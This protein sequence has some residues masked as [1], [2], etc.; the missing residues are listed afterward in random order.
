MI[1]A[2]RGTGSGSGER[3]PTT[4][5]MLADLMNNHLDGGYEAAARRRESRQPPSRTAQRLR[6]GTVLCCLGLIGLILA[7]AYSGTV[8]DAPDAARTRDALLD[9]V[10]R[11]AAET[12]RLGDRTQRLRETVADEQDAALA[13]DATGQAAARRLREAEATVG[14]AAVRGPGVAVELADGPPPTDPVTG[15]P[16][17]EA[18][19]GRVQDRDLQDVVNA[20]WQAG[21]EAVA[22][23]SQRLAATSTIRSAGQAIL[24]DFRPVDSPYVVSA[25]GDPDALYRA[26]VDSTTARRFRGYAKKYRMGFDV[27]R[28]DD[29]TLGAAAAPDLRFAQVPRAATAM[30]TSRGTPAS[31]EPPPTTPA[32]P[33]TTP[34]GGNR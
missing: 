16:T 15:Q 13:E 21:A 22:V 33:T 32:A 6:R 19:L 23:D 28:E 17:G 7:V 29:M 4:S 8:A 30:P 24:V 2:E 20:L 12:D 26:F 10:R 5:T 25:V 3:G 34:T 9:T 14:L 18:D 1:P 31:G 27:R 11:R